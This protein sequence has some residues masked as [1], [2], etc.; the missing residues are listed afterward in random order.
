MV[1]SSSILIRAFTQNLSS[2]RYLYVYEYGHI[3]A[4]PSVLRLEKPLN[5][6]QPRQISGLP[7][8]TRRSC[9]HANDIA[10]V[11]RRLPRSKQEN[12]RQ[13]GKGI[14]SSTKGSEFA[15]AFSQVVLFF[16]FDFFWFL[17]WDSMLDGIYDGRHTSTHW[18][19]GWLLRIRQ[20]SSGAYWHAVLGPLVEGERGSCSGGCWP[21][22]RTEAS[23]PT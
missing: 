4:A 15:R 16:P 3:E 7:S 17:C 21:S 19:T 18:N 14:I 12:H 8:P 11:P 22:T 23:P 1:G 5:P 9:S 10:S 2:F 6:F 20:Q 13:P